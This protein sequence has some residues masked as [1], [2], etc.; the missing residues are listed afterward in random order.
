MLSYV[1]AGSGSAFPQ[2]AENKLVVWSR[3]TSLKGGG[4]KEREKGVKYENIMERT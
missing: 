3:R 1:Q 2:G 4:E